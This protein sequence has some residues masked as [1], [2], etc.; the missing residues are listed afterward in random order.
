[1]FL[2]LRRPPTLLRS[3]HACTGIRL[4]SRPA[5]REGDREDD[6]G[7]DVTKH[8]RR[9]ESAKAEDWLNGEGRQFKDGKLGTNWLG[10]N[11]VR[12]LSVD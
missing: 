1:M 6:E 12:V 7:E 10:G 3:V 8:K 4:I 9:Q 2:A 11:V 5:T